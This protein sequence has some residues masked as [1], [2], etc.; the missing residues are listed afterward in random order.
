MAIKYSR[1]TDYAIRFKSSD[2][3]IESEAAAGKEIRLKST[4]NHGAAYQE[5]KWAYLYVDFMCDVRGV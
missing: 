3:I 1:I 4:I 5:N 2:Q